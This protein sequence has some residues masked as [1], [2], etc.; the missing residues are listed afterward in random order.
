MSLL[1]FVVRRHHLYSEPVKSKERLIVQ[2]GFRRF[3]CNPI[4]SDHTNIDKHKV[5]AAT[6]IIASSILV[7][8]SIFIL[9]SR[10]SALILGE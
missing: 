4:F 10:S 5:R 9:Q 6:T 8:A 1:N 2:C 3:A 7:L